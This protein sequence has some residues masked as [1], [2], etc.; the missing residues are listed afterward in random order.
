MQ[1]MTEPRVIDDDKLQAFA[2]TVMGDIA[3]ALT[4]LL[5]YVGDQTGV[6]RSMAEQG[7]ATAT[8]LADKAGVDARYLLEWLSA[9]AAAG[10]VQYDRA[11]E[12]FSLTPEQAVVLSAEGHPACMQGMI[13]LLTAQFTTHEKAVH[14]F[15]S[16]EGRAWGEHHACC[17]CG[18]DRF[19]RAG[20]NVNLLENWLPALEG[21]ESRL[22]AGGR[23]ADIG[24]GL[25]SST[26]LMA[27]A[28]PNSSFDGF[29]IHPPSIEEAGTRAAGHDGATNANFEA[30]SAVETPAN[31]YDLVCMFDCLHDMGDPVGAAR[32]IRECLAADGTLMLVEPLAGDALSDNLNPLGQLF[33]A[34]STLICTPASKAQEVGLALGAQAGE[35]RLTAVLREAGF[36]RIRRA[37]ETATNMVLEARP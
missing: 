26:L 13:Q 15:R 19:F 27:R 2:A 7:P 28:F 32:R 24:C 8:T 3:G 30:R 22:R 1:A 17:F 20:Y 10:Y 4:V 37:S 33:Y 5:G 16:G 9:Q 25:G 35:A 11:T 36:T 23:V 14:T 21:V 34:A 18:T 29:D 12:T 31:N 6:Y